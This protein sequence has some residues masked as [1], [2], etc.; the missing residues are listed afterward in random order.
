MEVVTWQQLNIHNKPI[1]I[2]NMDGFY[3]NFLQFIK[4]AIKNEFVSA[5]NG[6][7]IKVAH[8]V[9][10]VLLAIENYTVPEGRF[11]LNWEST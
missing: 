11:N 5:K 8:T 6:E 4:D 1:V 9:E 10:E 7:I 3:D 2:F